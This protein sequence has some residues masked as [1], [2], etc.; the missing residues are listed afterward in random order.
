MF[1]AKRHCDLPGMAD[2]PAARSDQKRSR[3]KLEML[4]DVAS[5]FVACPH[6][7]RLCG[8]LRKQALFVCRFRL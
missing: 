5:D 8:E 7:S 3:L 6:A 1:V 4:L 2:A